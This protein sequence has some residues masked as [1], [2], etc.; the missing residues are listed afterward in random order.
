MDA[1]MFGKCALRRGAAFP[2]TLRLLI[3]VSITATTLVQS[4]D[5]GYDSTTP[6]LLSNLVSCL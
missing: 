5:S 3:Y 4:S 6:L 1:P 2:A